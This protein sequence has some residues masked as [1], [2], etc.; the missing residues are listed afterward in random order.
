MAPRIVWKNRFVLAGLLSLI[1]FV[2]LLPLGQTFGGIPGPDLAMCLM[3]AF[4]LRRP[5]YVP[6]GL[7]VIMGFAADALL[8]KPL[9]LW[10]L[11]LLLATEFLRRSVI[12]TEALTPA[13]EAAQ[14]V[15]VMIVCFLF[16][17]LVLLGLVADPPAFFSQLI[18]IGMTLLFYPLIV[19]FTHSILGVRRLQP[20]EVDTL[21]GR[22]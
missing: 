22:A 13:D 11:T 8:M 20:G 18:H 16:E 21:G 17:R 12:H 15:P 19:V 14:V 4:V 5:D 3:F 6:I 2:N 10:T 9:G 1:I 7:V